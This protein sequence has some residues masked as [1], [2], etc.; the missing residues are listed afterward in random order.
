MILSTAWRIAQEPTSNLALIL[1]SKYHAYTSICRANSCCPN[2]AFWAAIL[3][4]KPLLESACFTQIVDG[5]S[6][7]W[8][9]PW[10][11]CWQNIYNYLVIQQPPFNYP[12]TIK[13][14]WIPNLKAWNH[15]LVNSLFTPHVATTILNTPIIDDVGQVMLAVNGLLQE[16]FYKKRISTLF[17]KSAVA[18]EQ[19]PKQVPWQVID[20]LNQVWD[21][22]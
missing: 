5:F 10:F 3:K 6:S 2:S 15:D 22:K 21:D 17:Q 9:T 19:M 18:A 16:V 11:N 4:V 20:L 8:R 1:K 14:L 13:D 7:I 12:A